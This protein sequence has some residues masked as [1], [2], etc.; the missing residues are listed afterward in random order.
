ML[1]SSKLSVDDSPLGARI[2]SGCVPI[3][4]SLKRCERELTFDALDCDALE[5]NEPL[6]LGIEIPGGYKPI[7]VSA[8]G[9]E[10]SERRSLGMNSASGCEPILLSSKGSLFRT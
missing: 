7:L 1:L 2:C 6:T 5:I 4:T 8:K 9:S 10:S 3:L